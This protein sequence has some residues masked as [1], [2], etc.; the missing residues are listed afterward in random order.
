[1]CFRYELFLLW[2]MI[3]RVWCYSCELSVF[4]DTGLLWENNVFV[5]CLREC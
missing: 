2:L 4:V 5:F 1:M 3:D